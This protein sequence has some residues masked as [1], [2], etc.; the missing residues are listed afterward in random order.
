MQWNTTESTRGNFNF[1]DADALVNWAT[2]N[3]KLIRGRALVWQPQFPLWVSS[4]SDKN[5]LTSVIQ[6]HIATVAGRY[7]GKIYCWDVCNEILNVDGSLRTSVFSNTLGESFVTIAFAAAKAADSGARLYITDDNMDSNNAKTQ[8][9]IRLITRI[10]ASVKYI[11]GVGSTIRFRHGVGGAGGLLDALTALAAT[12]VDVAIVDLQ[13][14]GATTA[15]YLSVMQACLRIS[16]PNNNYKAL[17][18]A[19]RLS[20]AAATATV[21]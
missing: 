1:G 14:Y 21:S 16:K 13:I 12:G 10:N 6:N 18:S 20:T 11:E 17:T 7:K 19:L 5:T 15:D 2:S 9:M 8:G 3:G 4:I